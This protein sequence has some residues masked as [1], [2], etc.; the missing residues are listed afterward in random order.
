MPKYNTAELEFSQP[1]ARQ[2][3]HDIIG[4]ILYALKWPDTKVRSSLIT[5]LVSQPTRRFAEIMADFDRV[6]GES[7]LRVACS[8][9]LKKLVSDISAVGVEE[10]PLQGPV[11]ITSNHPG[12]YDSLSILS[13]LPREDAKIIVGANPFFH[14]MLNGS[15]F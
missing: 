13:Q 8:H 4:E 6:I 14:D 2:L 7:G 1:L 9:I 15:D 3:K 12:T 11:L 10:I 5:T